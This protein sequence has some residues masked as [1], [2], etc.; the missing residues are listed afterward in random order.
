M[1]EWLLQTFP[2]LVPAEVRVDP[3]VRRVQAFVDET[4]D[5]K[6]SDG[7]LFHW[8]R[9]AIQPVAPEDD[10]V[11]DR[12][13]MLTDANGFRNAAPEQPTYDIVAVGDSFTRASGTA[14]PWPQ[15]LAQ[16]TDLQ[17]LNLGEVGAGPQQELAIL[18]QHGLDKAPR[19]V[20]LAY[21]EGNDLNDAGA[22]AQASPLILPRLGRYLLSRGQAIMR[23]SPS[24]AGG[25]AIAPRYRY[26]IT[27]TLNGADVELA[28]LSYYVSWLALGRDDLGA[29]RN[30]QVMQETTLTMR[31]LCTAAGAHFL[32][33]YVPSKEHVYL[34]FV[35]GA[36][37]LA[38]VF[39]DVPTLALDEARY[40]Q[41][42]DQP[43]TAELA[44]Q[45][46]DDQARLL[47]DFAAEHSILF[48]DLTAIFQ[49]EAAAGMEL[50][51]PFDTHWN[52][53]GHDLAADTI[54]AYLENLSVGAARNEPGRSEI[55]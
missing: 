19:W 27:V 24:D 32:V 38:S 4:Y 49:A 34:P 50:Y 25:P 30:Y 20:I 7:D 28:F 33:V 52:Q 37:N 29:S 8:M 6:L 18:R 1:A 2:A 42:T 53:R 55:R 12:V 47:G 21:F 14:F 31:D 13:H 40:L 39:A 46:L 35:R 10:R 44:R 54:A 16:A 41:F 3:P 5:V 48:L 26:P 9:G 22:Y 36:E 15:R 51:L 43:A 23:E 17:V 45:H 11:L